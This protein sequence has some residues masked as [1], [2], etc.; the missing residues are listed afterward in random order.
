[1]KNL[2]KI[3]VFILAAMVFNLGAGAGVIHIC[4]TYCKMQACS[5]PVHSH[6]DMYGCCHHTNGDNVQTSVSEECSCINVH[7]NID[8]FKVSQDDS[9]V[10]FVPMPFDLPEHI[11][12][13][14]LPVLLEFLS[15]Q[16]SNSPPVI[17][18]GRMLL[19]FHSVLII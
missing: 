2:C 7:Y 3:F 13:N 6:A 14:F 1:M 10:S 5:S 8:L 16:S 19:A 15:S 12:Y 17:H 9:P 18:G 11:T 4:S